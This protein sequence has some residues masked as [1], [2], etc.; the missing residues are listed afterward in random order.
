MPKSP[1]ID[2]T[3]SVE[4]LEAQ[5]RVAAEMAIACGMDAYDFRRASCAA[6]TN[7]ALQAEDG[8]KT[9]AARRVGIHRNSL[10]YR[11]RVTKE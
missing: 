5:L 11:L 7:A 2:V 8:N 9:R 3:M 4:E 1:H 6:I 10:V